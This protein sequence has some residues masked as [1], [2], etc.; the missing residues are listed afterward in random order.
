MAATKGGRADPYVNHP[1]AV[2]ALLATVAGIEDEHILA[3][4]L[5]H[6][7]LEDTDATSIELRTQFGAAVVGYVQEVTDDK[8]LPKSERIRLLLARA[9]HMSHG[10]KL[11][12]MADQIH[13][14]QSLLDDPPVLWSM[15]RRADYCSKASTVCRE[16][17][18]TNRCLEALSAQVIG[19][20]MA[21]IGANTKRG[22]KR[23]G[24]RDR[25][26]IPGKG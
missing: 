23:H 15:E 18:G 3:A 16:L 9:P 6:D 1:L 11:I 21:R 7:T 17:A 13:N 19:Q 5:L 20:C 24:H 25:A 2:A 10:A 14:L 22:A 4:A 26:Q 8:T 12:K